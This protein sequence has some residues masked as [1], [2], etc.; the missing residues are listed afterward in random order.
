MNLDDK[1]LSKIQVASGGI[2]ASFLG[3]H[4]I[5]TMSALGGQ[6]LYDGLQDVFRGYY[7]TKLAEPVLLGSLTVHMGVG[8]WKVYRR[9]TRASKASKATDYENEETRTTSI[10]AKTE[11]EKAVESPSSGNSSNNQSSAFKTW[12]DNL[13]P[14]KLHR[15]TGYFLTA[16]AAGHALA[17]RLPYWVYGNIVD[18][19]YVSFAL[20]SW[21]YAFYPYYILFATA[22]LYHMSYGLVQSVKMLN[23]KVPDWASPRNKLFWVYFATGSLA[24]IGGVLSFS[25]A[26]KAR[27]PLWKSQFE[28]VFPESFLPWKNPSLGRFASDSI[29]QT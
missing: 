11:T 12:I 27:Y 5:N 7:Q 1:T 23:G 14:L 13:N 17:L 15:Y 19:S 21:P 10:S 22:G 24:L 3:L 20:D 6:L 16:F 18:M 25:G 26:S 29:V 2:F 28:D 8:V 4:L 9:W